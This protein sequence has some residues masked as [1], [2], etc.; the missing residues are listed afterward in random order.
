MHL[1]LGHSIQLPSPL[2]AQKRLPSRGRHLDLLYNSQ[3]NLSYSVN[4]LEILHQSFS[5]GFPEFYAGANSLH[6]NRHTL[7]IP[8]VESENAKNKKYRCLSGAPKRTRTRETVPTKFN[9]NFKSSLL[10]S[11]LKESSILLIFDEFVNF[12]SLSFQTFL[13]PFAIQHSSLVDYLVQVIY[14]KKIPTTFGCIF[15]L[16]LESDKIS[17]SL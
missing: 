9:G 4:V 10:I 7:D 13:R 17:F 3:W 1:F 2:L 12:S 16:V 8:Q 5:P 15:Q 14:E 11:V 6:T